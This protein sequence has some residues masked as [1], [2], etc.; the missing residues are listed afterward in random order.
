MTSLLKKAKFSLTENGGRMTSQRRL[1]IET[2]EGL[3][4]HPTAEELYEL[5]H[6][7]D[8]DLNLSTVYRTLRWLEGEGLVNSRRFEVDRGQERF[9]PQLADEHYHFV[10][11]TC[12]SVIE[13][14]APVIETI[15]DQIERQFGVQVE[16]ASVVLHGYCP[17]CHPYSEAKA[18]AKENST[19]CTVI[20]P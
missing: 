14:N 17:E 8:P 10:C 13:F 15:I 19:L 4:S 7:R 20:Q 3:A 18:V 16:S 5:V 6:E 1:I 9:D 11:N 12:K 2:L